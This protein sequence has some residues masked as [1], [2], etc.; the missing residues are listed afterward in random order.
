MNA[1]EMTNLG[2]KMDEIKERTKAFS[3][4]YQTIRMTVTEALM[5]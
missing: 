5:E 2:N 1:Q 4:K 3:A